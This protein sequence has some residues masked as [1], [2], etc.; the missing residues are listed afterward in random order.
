MRPG[1]FDKHACWWTSFVGDHNHQLAYFHPSFCEPMEEVGI[2]CGLEE[3]FLEV[4]RIDPATGS[5]FQVK[6]TGYGRPLTEEIAPS[7]QAEGRSP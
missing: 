2:R 4:I 3:V 6:D 7:S 5:R 1:W